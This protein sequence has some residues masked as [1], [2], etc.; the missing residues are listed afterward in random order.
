MIDVRSRG[1]ARSWRHTARS[2][3]IAAGAVVVAVLTLSVSPAYAAT[4]PTWEELQAAKSNESAKAAQIANI[5]SLIAQTQ[6][7]VEQ[8]QAAAEKAGQEYQD[9]R[10]KFDE[11]DTTAKALQT[12]ADSSKA[13]SEAATARAG[14]LAAQLYRTGG[15]ELSANLL[16]EGGEQSEQFLSKLGRASKLTEINS[17]VY[18]S[19]VEARNAAQSLSD[20]ADVALQARE[21]LR[22]I[23]EGKLAE[24]TAASQAAQAQL[25]AQND[26]NA[27]LNAQLAVLQDATASTQAQYDEGVAERRRQ[28]AAAAAAAGSGGAGLDAGQL[29]DQGW[30]VPASGRITDNYG[31]RPSQPAGAGSF[32]RGTDIGTGCGAPIYAATG[33][34]VSYAGPNG[35]YGNWIEIRHGDGVSTGYA[36][37]RPGGI[38]V[39]VG[40]QVSAGQNIASSG[41]TGASTGCHLHFE[42]RINGSA[43]DAVPFM[44]DR[45]AALG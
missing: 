24:A 22:V 39:D 14:L 13:E 38:F 31:P 1:G 5:Q 4:Y 12:Q 7:L 37:I 8:T 28:A 6:S 35:T 3:L 43:I 23:A 40:E 21:G 41:T 17:G 29:S 33:G 19:A 2:R 10:E 36:H 45:G 42:V 11:A 16:L 9:A 44:R 34:T 25:Q 26:E 18:S 15:T 27:I 20:Q 30:A 32:H